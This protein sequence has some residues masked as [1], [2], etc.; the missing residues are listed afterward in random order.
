MFRY[1][2]AYAFLTYS[3]VPEMA[4]LPLVATHIVDQWRTMG[5]AQITACFERHVDGGLHV[6]ALLRHTRQFDTTRVNYFDLDFDMLNSAAVHPNIKRGAFSSTALSN[7]ITYIHKP[8]DAIGDDKVFISEIAGPV[9]RQGRDAVVTEALAMESFDDYMD[10]VKTGLPFNYAMSFGNVRACGLHHFPPPN[11]NT[12][13][14]SRYTPDEF[15]I[16]PAM[17]EY[18]AKYLTPGCVYGDRPPSLIVIGKS[19]LG[20]TQW[21]RSYAPHAYLKDMFSLAPLLHPYDYVVLDDINLGTLHSYKGLLGGQADI[22]LTDKYAKKATIGHGKPCIVLTNDPIPWEKLD[23][24]WMEANC[25]VVE[26]I[27]PL[28]VTI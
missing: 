3:Q 26:L 8:D 13:F 27:D 1:K 23:R 24:A 28:Y 6:H 12:T 18:A 4:A 20:K 10:T 11:P 16:P 25:I 5:A 14:C 21:A 17:D 19:R 22:T 7:F 2:A 15:W 9:S